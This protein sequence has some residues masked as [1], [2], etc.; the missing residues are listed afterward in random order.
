MKQAR[1]NSK[2]RVVQ[3]APFV[4]DEVHP[5]TGLEFIDCPEYVEAGYTYDPGN[6]SWI[7]PEP[8]PEPEV[9][10]DGESDV[11]TYPKVSPVEF[12]LLL[13]TEERVSLR[14]AIETD[15]GIADLFDLIDDQRMK[16]VDL[17]LGSV[18]DAIGYALEFLSDQ[19]IVTDIA[20]RMEEI[21][22]GKLR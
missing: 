8:K 13:T 15:P 18:Q 16:H 3:T 4:W 11:I 2:N 6:D 7:E 14:G 17:N 1:L 5:G 20:V 19:G 21:L 10:S 22:S 12:K 9:D